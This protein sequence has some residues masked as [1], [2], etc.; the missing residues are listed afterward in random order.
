MHRDAAKMED[1][2][3]WARIQDDPVGK[4]ALLQQAQQLGVVAPPQDLQVRVVH[5]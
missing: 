5:S 2:K 3:R 1:L 4:L